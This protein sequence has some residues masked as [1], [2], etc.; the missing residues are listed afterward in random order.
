MKKRK[1]T[2][3]LCIT[4]LLLSTVPLQN[5]LAIDTPTPQNETSNNV[6]TGGGIPSTKMQ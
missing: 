6:N 1:I 5:V 4:T 3:G 2:A